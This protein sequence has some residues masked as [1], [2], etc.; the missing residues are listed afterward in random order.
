M[1]TQTISGLSEQDRTWFARERNNIFFA[2]AD[3]YI[4]MCR[5]G[6]TVG[7]IYRRYEMTFCLRLVEPTLAL[8]V[9][10]LSEAY[11]SHQRIVCEY[12][13]IEME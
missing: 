5:E 11:R 8:L 2:D 9:I 1:P 6:Y 10:S 12:L 3:L 13:G 7:V 4:G